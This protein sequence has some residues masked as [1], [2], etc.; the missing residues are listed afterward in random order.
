MRRCNPILREIDYRT[1][2][3]RFLNDHGLTGAGAEIGVFSGDFSKTIMETWKGRMLYLV[4]P[5]RKFAKAEYFDSTQNYD[6]DGVYRD[7]QNKLAPWTARVA[8]VRL[9][10]LEASARFADGE[11]DWVFIDANHSYEASQADI[12]AWYPKVRSGGLFSGHD[13]YTR[14]QDT[15]SDALNSVLDFAESID[16]RPHVTWCNSWWFIKP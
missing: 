11:L 6:Q 4:D 1:E 8:F 14:L 9:T 5:Y 2:L 7:A 12:A 10:S 15:T 3:P 16:T 13:F